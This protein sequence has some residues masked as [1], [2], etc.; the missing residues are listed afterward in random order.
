MLLASDGASDYGNKF[1]EPV[2]QGFARTYGDIIGAG[3]HKLIDY[4]I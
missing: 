4:N 2:I 1:G 3:K